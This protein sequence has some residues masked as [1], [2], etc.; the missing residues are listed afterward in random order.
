M[1]GEALEEMEKA[2]C[3][4]QV[5]TWWQH[6]PSASSG[7]YTQVSP[8]S[9]VR[10]WE[11]H[12]IK[13]YTNSLEATFLCGWM[14]T[15]WRYGEKKK[16]HRARR[17]NKLQRTHYTTANVKTWLTRGVNPIMTFSLSEENTH[18]HT[19]KPC[20]NFHPWQG[21]IIFTHC[22]VLLKLI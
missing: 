16:I 2:F 21:C 7:S 8:V 15:C 11:I 22:N 17:H 10:N 14:V 19:H 12:L 13:I 1:Q 18:T 9:L 6:L 4:E 3:R 20:C 5:L